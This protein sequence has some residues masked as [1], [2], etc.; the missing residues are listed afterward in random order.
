M[1]A[2]LPE[3]G[4]PM[5]KMLV[6]MLAELDKETGRRAREDEVARRGSAPSSP[7]VFTVRW[8]DGNWRGRK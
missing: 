1:I 2:T 3:A 4:R 8:K 6:D 7:I 5:F